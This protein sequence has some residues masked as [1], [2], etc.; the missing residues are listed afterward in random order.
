MTMDDGMHLLLTEQG[1]SMTFN[2]SKDGNCQFSA[3]AHALSEYGIF[4][5]S[6]T[7]QYEVVE[8][9]WNNPSN[10][11][12]F[13][14]D[15][16]LTQSWEDYLYEMSHHGIYDGQITLQAVSDML[17]VEILVISTLVSKGRVWISPRSVI[18]Q[19][20]AILGHFPEGEGIHYVAMRPQSGIFYF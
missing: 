11:E 17:R 10:A 16:F 1:Y 2:L 19:C 6:T 18:P 12:G 15:V 20:R 4:R 8:Y 9:L 14:F 7:L 13:P 3:L 5:S